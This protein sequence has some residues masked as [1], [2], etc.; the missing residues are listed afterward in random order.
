MEDGVHLGGG[1]PQGP[2]AGHGQGTEHRERGTQQ[3]AVRIPLGQVWNRSAVKA[4][5]A[6]AVRRQR[7]EPPPGAGRRRRR[8]LS[9]RRGRARPR[10][11]RWRVARPLP[12]FRARRRSAGRS[13][14]SRR[15]GALPFRPVS[16]ATG[17]CV[18]D[19]S[20][21]I[22]PI[23][24]RYLRTAGSMVQKCR[25]PVTV[26]LPVPLSG[27]PGA[28]VAR[29]TGRG[30]TAYAHRK[31][32]GADGGAGGEPSGPDRGVPGPYPFRVTRSGCLPPEGGVRR[33]VA[34]GV[35]R[36]GGAVGVGGQVPILV[37]EPRRRLSLGVVR[38]AGSARPVGVAAGGVAAFLGR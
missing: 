13:G 14:Q 36:C 18:P 29:R 28:G 10:P 2:G 31:W 3:V 20:S 22:R 38:G 7:P 25:R 5:T 37:D 12:R 34:P 11:G 1:L 6:A 19:L 26:G 8:D 35:G 23:V 16:V 30:N 27:V 9:R 33:G 32:S 17:W 21:A 4:W 15:E 24:R